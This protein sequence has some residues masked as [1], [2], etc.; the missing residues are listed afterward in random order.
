MKTNNFS[1]IKK[2]NNLLRLLKKK[3]K[4][5]QDVQHGKQEYTYS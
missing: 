3:Y 5:Y 4:N 2:I 1:G